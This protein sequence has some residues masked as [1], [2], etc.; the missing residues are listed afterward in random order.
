LYALTF[1]VARCSSAIFSSGS[2]V[3]LSAATIAFEISS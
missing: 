1:E 3:S 2:S